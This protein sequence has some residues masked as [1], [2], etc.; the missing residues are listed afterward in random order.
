MGG[1]SLTKDSLLDGVR[2]QTQV[3]SG[4]NLGE[5]FGGFFEDGLNL[6]SNK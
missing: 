3:L 6:N 4:C 2:N 5:N 1:V